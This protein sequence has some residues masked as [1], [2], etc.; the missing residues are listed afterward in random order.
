[1]QARAAVHEEAGQPL[2]IE[3][4]E[5]LPPRQGEVLVRFVAAGVCHSD[6]HIMQGKMH[7]PTPVV[8]GHEGA[9][10]VEAVGPGVTTV[11]VGDH[12]LTSYQP[13]CGHCP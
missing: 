4:L 11:Q 8:L 2:R 12:V 13:T 7:W 1:M 6:L 10:V 5:V 3:T 9:G